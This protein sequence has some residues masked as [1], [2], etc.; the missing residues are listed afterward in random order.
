MATSQWEVERQNRSL[1]KRIRIAQSEKKNWKEELKTYL[2]MY[3]A[4]PHSVTGISPA[5]LMFGKY[6]IS[7]YRKCV[8]FTLI[9]SKFVT[10]I[11]SSTKK[12]KRIQRY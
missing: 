3:R 12:K 4:A 11:Q 2:I 10:E 9:I 6:Q 5:E 8:T 7:K 1:M